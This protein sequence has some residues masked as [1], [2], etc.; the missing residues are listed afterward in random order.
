M[1]SLIMQVVA[2]EDD[3]LLF[4]NPDVSASIAAGVPS[5][6]VYLTAGNLSG[7]GTTD[8]QRTRNRQRG[9]QDAYARMAG[10][11]TIAA[12]QADWQGDLLTIAGKQAERYRL[13]GRTDVVL[14][15]L[16]L[17][18]GQLA[19][20]YSG[21]TDKTVIPEAGLVTR[22][23]SYTSADVVAVL[24]GLLA[25]YQPS[26]L[27]FQDLGPDIRYNPQEHPDHRTT[28][29]F[30]TDAANSSS[31]TAIQVSYRDYEI[32]ES[33]ANLSPA[34]LADKN[35]T[36]SLY[37]K[38][39][40]TF[41]PQNWPGRMYRR[42][43]RGTNWV[44]N[45]ADGR[46]QAFVVRNGVVYTHS[47]AARGGWS[48]PGALGGAGGPLAPTLAVGYNADG[49][50]A[51]FAHRMSD[52][53]IVTAYQ[54]A[55]NGGWTTAWVDL[56]SP[57]AGLNNYDQIGVP[58]ASRNADGRMQ[59]FV[60]NA[61]GGLSTKSQT[62]VN[63]SW[64]AWLDLHGTDVQDHVAPVLNASGRIEVFAATRTG[65]QHWA[66]S[67]P[68]GGFILDTLPTPAPASL[69][70]VTIA[71]NGCV[72]L[73]YRQADSA[74]VMIFSQA[75]SG[76]PF[77]ATPTILAGQTGLGELAMLSAPP[78]PNARV[79]V[80]A[81]GPDTALGMN[82]ESVPAG[83]YGTWSRLDGPTIDFAAAVDAAGLVNVFRIGPDG[84]LNRSRQDRVGGTTF[85][86]W[87]PLG[88]RVPGPRRGDRTDLGRPAPRRPGVTR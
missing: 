4:M 51:I 57:N 3:D 36:L 22:S 60:K 7:T 46:L 77:N 63:G 45:N 44:G 54:T 55:P 34:A 28:V 20:V 81:L 50:M 14:L 82:M 23:F 5:V 64:S 43:A 88:F 21:M 26:V 58:A 72:R 18:D 15:F 76:G 40:S 66:Q 70:Q 68:N 11:T 25:T 19:N 24:S 33:V 10:L 84:L 17:H 38:Y 16:N 53:H 85:G 12:N 83:P 27:R 35:A 69:A 37:A 74:E 79:T 78:G 56:G 42:W 39:D 86:P 49:R 71:A 73:A 52:H 1:P 48:A 32:G 2:H 62:A 47:Q 29:R 80:F 41:A 13:T 61:G 6:T 8:E 30:I 65:V 75:S 59:I 67:Q 9:V 31:S 87:Q